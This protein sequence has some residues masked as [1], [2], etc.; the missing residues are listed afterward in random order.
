MVVENVGI[1]ELRQ[2]SGEDGRGDVGVADWLDRRG[3]VRLEG[4]REGREEGEEELILFLGD[5]VGE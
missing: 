5:R 2:G 1:G 4:L 3:E